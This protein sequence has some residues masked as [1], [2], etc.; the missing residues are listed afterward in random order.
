MSRSR[1]L[2]DCASFLDSE[3]A[4]NLVRVEAVA[5]R[6]IVLRFLES[7]YEGLGC[8]P[9]LVDGQ[10]MQ[11]LLLEQLPSHYGKGDP[12]AADTE[13][14]LRAYYSFLSE[15]ELVP[16]LFEIQCA[17][18]DHSEAF[19]SI[20]DSGAALSN[21]LPVHGKGR[22]VR[23]RGE[24]VGRNDP[25]PCGSGKKFKHCCMRLGEP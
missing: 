6:K 7:C 14:V 17:L 24:K 21:G 25:C 16:A 8:A 22:T 2:L 3:A 12:L 9:K 4:R 10:G 11:S 1:L 20:V 5:R 23:H 13:E 19:R 18:L 15:A